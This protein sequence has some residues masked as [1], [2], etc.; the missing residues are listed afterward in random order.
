MRLAAVITGFWALA[1]ACVFFIVP[2]V[3]ITLY[4]MRGGDWRGAVKLALIAAVGA[5]AGG[6]ILYTWAS[7]DYGGASNFIANLPAIDTAM[8]RN[9]ASDYATGGFIEMLKG[10]FSGVPY[11]LYALAAVEQGQSFG[12]LMLQ[13]SLARLPRFL[14]VA[15]GASAVSWCLRSLSPRIRISVMLAF[16]LAFYLWYFSA[17]P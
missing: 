1:E 12:S 6:A 4:A 16:W 17:M 5:M 2:D 3:P 7:A 14:T 13:T 15:L 8:M 11:K 10:A 9:T